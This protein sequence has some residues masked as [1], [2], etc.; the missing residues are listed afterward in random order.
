MKKVLFPFLLAILIIQTSSLAFAQ[1]Q[2]EIRINQYSTIEGPDAMT[3]RLYFNIYDDRTGT[4]MLTLDAQSAQVTLLNTNYTVN[5]EI[6]KPDVPI[7]IT[8]VLDSSGS[9]GGAAKDLQDAAKLALNN[10]PDNSLFSIVQFDE[11]IQLLQDFT[12]NIP[13]LQFAIDRY[14]VSRNGTCLYDAA[15][16]A[17]EAMTKAP[18]GRRA[19]ILFTDGKDENKEGKPCSKHTYQELVDFAM[20][21]QVP[22][23]TIGLSYNQGAINSLELESLAGS[24]GGVSAVATQGNLA[25]SFEKIMQALKAQWMLEATIYPRRGSNDG[26]FNLTLK[27]GTS[28]STTFNI[29]SNTDYPG[30]PSPVVAKFAGLQLNAAKQAYE[31]QL[32][33]TSSD[34]VGYVKIE[35]WDTDGGSKVGEFVFDHPGPNNS[36]F[37]PTEKLTV[38]RGYQLRITAVGKDDNVPFEIA[39]D[40]NGKGLTELIHEFQFDPSASYPSLQIQSLSEEKSGDLTLTVNVTNPDLIGGFDGW[41]VDEGTNTQVPNS[42]FTVSAISDTTGTITLPMRANRVPNGKY[43]VIVRVLAKNNNVYSTAVY[44]GLVYNAPSIFSR[45]GVALVAAPIFLLGI[46]IVIAAVVGFL[47]YNSSRQKSLSGTPVLQGRLGGQ[48]KMGKQSGPSIPVADN[49]PIPSRDRPKVPPMGAARAA[50]TPLPKQPTS[51]D[52]TMIANDVIPESD[53]ATVIASSPVIPLATL[54]V[55][56]SPENVTP[57][58]TVTV[59]TFPFV[60]GRTEGSL[61]IPDKNVS[62]KHVQ[63]TY[64][65]TTN[66]YYLTDLNSSNGTRIDSQRV[67]PGQP[68]YLSNGAMI[69][70]GPNVV[71]RFE[72]S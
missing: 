63:I 66:A 46:L 1:S 28:F 60:V 38:G 29:N 51:S 31:V 39:R 59:K 7:Y 4:S 50:S 68:T 19:V 57:S 70:I 15:Y 34:L 71:V 30:P 67:T 5:G 14:K 37:I 17:V 36:F 56:Q 41:L 47:M 52:A 49:E 12:E 8:L 61:I 40:D 35:V 48:V 42:N 11:E 10:T 33:L 58:K 16:S 54:T 3:L 43:T 9:M 20:K 25:A 22:I 64:N 65:S 72:I 62:R 18:V 2:G 24:T 27:D 26:V 6:K 45:I 21:S 13:A 53:S 23:S 32:D 55:V 44:E 69:S